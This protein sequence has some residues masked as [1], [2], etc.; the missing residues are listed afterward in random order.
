[1]ETKVE[2]IILV[3]NA[4]SGFI[5]GLFDAGHKLLSPQTYQC[6]LCSLTHGAFKERGVWRQF[7]ES[8]SIEFEFLHID[9]FEEEY[10]QLEDKFSYPI[11]AAESEG[12]FSVLLNDEQ[13]RSLKNVDELINALKKR[14]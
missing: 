2:K 7:R 13:L 11:V 3:Y 8:S 4:K 12:Y 1:M 14:I 5:H 10:E 6:S 9:E